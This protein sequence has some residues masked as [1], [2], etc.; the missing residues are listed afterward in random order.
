MQ[1]RS[2]QLF[3]KLNVFDLK[4]ITTGVTKLSI[5]LCKEVFVDLQTIVID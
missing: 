3:S 1:N 5:G 2:T 4:L